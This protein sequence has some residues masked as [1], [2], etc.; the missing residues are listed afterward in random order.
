MKAEEEEVD[1]DGGIDTDNESAKKKAAL[2]GAPGDEDNI[3]ADAEPDADGE[4]WTM[5]VVLGSETTEYT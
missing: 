1:V 4:T 5:R 2:V 3:W